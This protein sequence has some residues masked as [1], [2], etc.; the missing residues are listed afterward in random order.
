MHY[1]CEFADARAA[2]RGHLVCVRFAGS[3]LAY[4]LCDVNGRVKA[5]DRTGLLL[6]VPGNLELD[7][8]EI[9]SL[10]PWVAIERVSVGWTED[11]FPEEVSS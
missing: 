2:L 10:I 8:S 3:A 6:V 7:G 4:G 1:L 11:I 9:V 5:S